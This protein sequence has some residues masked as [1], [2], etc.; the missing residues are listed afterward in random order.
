M[1]RIIFDL[2]GTL[3]ESAPSL[4]AAANALLGELGRAPLVGGDDAELRR[5]RGAGAGRAGAATIPAGCRA[6]DS[7]PHLE[8]FRAIYN[9]DPVTGT[10]PIPGV[11]AALAAL[12]AAGHG[13]GVC[14]QKPNLPAVAILKALG[15]MPPIDGADRRRQPRRDEAGPADARAMP[16][17]SFPRGR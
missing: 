12:A 10:E 7:G 5:A 4:T 17:P 3:V 1:A 15:L 11:P 16:R 14:T 2:D 13:L 6:A 8:R 9:A